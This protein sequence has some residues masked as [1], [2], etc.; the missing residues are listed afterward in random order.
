MK[1]IFT[2]LISLMFW[3]SIFAQPANY[4]YNPAFAGDGTFTLDQPVSGIVTRTDQ[5]SSTNNTFYIEWDSQF[6]EWFNTSIDYNS[7]FTLTFEGASG[8]N[9]TSTLN[10]NPTSGRY[11]TLQIDGLAY[12][13]RSAVFMETDNNP[14]DFAASS[15]ISP[16][17]ATVYPGQAIEFTITL[18]GN[19]ST[20]E[21]AFVRY[22][23]DSF[24]SDDNVAEVSFS[25]STASTGTV[26]IPS[27]ANTA[28]TSITYYF[29]TTT[30]S[31]TSSSNHDLITLAIENNSGSNY[32]YT[33]ESASSTDADGNWNTATN[34]AGDAIPPDG[35]PIN[36]NNDITLDIATVS[37]GAV[38]VASG[39]TLAIGS[40]TLNAGTNTVSGDG[41]ITVST[42][43]ITSGIIS[44][45]T[46]T[47]T[48]AASVNVTGA[49]SVGTFT[50]S[51]ST[52][53]TT[54]D[55]SITVATNFYNFTNNSGTRTLDANIDIEG[56]LT[57]SGGDMRASTGR[58]ITM[59]GNSAVINVTSGTITGTDAGGGNDISLV[60][61]GD[62][63][64][65]QGGVSSGAGLSRKFFNIT[66]DNGSKLILQRGILC[67]YGTFTVNGTLQIDPNGFVE[68]PTAVADAKRP[69]YHA[70]TG[71]LIYNTGGDYTTAGEWSL[72]NPPPSLTVQSSTDLKLSESKALTNGTLTL[73]S[74]TIELNGGGLT[75]DNVTISN[76]NSTNFIITSSTN[77]LTINSIGGATTFPI[78]PSASLY[79]PVILDN[80]S[81][82]SDNFSV[83]V[84][85]DFTNTPGHE[86]ATVDAYWTIS[87]STGGG[88]D[89]ALTLQ[90]NGSQEGAEFDNPGEGIKI[91]RNDGFGQDGWIGTSATINGSGPYTAA[92]SGF[93]QFG[94][95]AIGEGDAVPV[96]LVSFTGQLMKNSAE[97]SWNT[98]TEIDNYGFE[99]ERSST[100]ADGS[101]SE[102]TVVGFVEGHGNSNAPKNYSY[103]NELDENGTYFY[104]LK[105]IDFDG[106]YEFSPTIEI[107][108]EQLIDG[109]V[110]EQNYPNPFN[111]TTT[112]K[113]GFEN[114][115]KTV[116][117]I[118]N[119]LGE[120]V[121]E[122]FNGIADAGRIYNVDFNGSGLSSGIY[123]YK[124]V[125]PDRTE[126]KKMM[127]VK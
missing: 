44:L 53:T 82:T 48:G 104:R 21:K 11:Y 103:S 87:E 120:K 60:I 119:S 69:A 7:E 50:K 17:S 98:A 91:G 34:W 27:I 73:T 92:A 124:L 70:S 81:G 55:A 90:W 123:Y 65:V 41:A 57:V 1:R 63:T 118:Y 95:F 67:R 72:T 88:S 31:A 102:W 96:E 59:S 97:L 42:G 64:Q 110:L 52:V 83:R 4:Y 111:P 62:E 10:T 30:V 112:I 16:A 75:L 115:T 51:T 76:A 35:T 24:A 20:Q 66:V 78:G 36:I 109:F 80:T 126:I 106:A 86:A 85:S 32:S 2:I 68:T 84:S 61:S 94:E 56:T 12:S 40:N 100:I 79:N 99:V 108:F 107:A 117:T 23:N 8:L 47:A 3:G 14:I 125:T 127:L 13:D 46:L 19:K 5:A 18:S 38:T 43:S 77:S 22:S 39:K 9:N 101:K 37:T 105:Q 93:S 28:G 89:V 121:R 33:V 45:N 25:T 71:V 6:N 74:G 58:T 114:P 15:P 116:I 54:G 122:L 49:W 113:F 26:S 29:Y